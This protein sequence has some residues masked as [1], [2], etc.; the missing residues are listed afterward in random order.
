MTHFDFYRPGDL[1]EALEIVSQKGR[2]L[3]LAGGTNLLVDM[4][5]APF[6][7]HRLVDLSRLEILQQIE[8]A[9]GYIRLGAGVKLAEILRW[10]PGGAVEGLLHPM[11]A[12][13]AGPQIRNLATVGGNLCHA[14]PA[15]D[16]SPPLLALDARIELASA[17]SGI[18][19]VGLEDFF[20]GVRST[21]R[22]TDEIATVVEI[23]APDGDE[24]S[25]YYKLAKRRADA[26]S[27]V[28]VAMTLRLVAGKV[29][30]ARI[31]LGAVAPIA[32]RA[33]EAE[34]ILIGEQLKET[35][36]S[37]AAAKAATEVQP[38]DDF[39]AS[40]H[41]RQEM[42]GVL[43]KRGLVQMGSAVPGR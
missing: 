18:R 38:I 7:A 15:A 28:S 42:V 29:K 3:P 25:F 12:A 4:K 36:I 13:F 17:R 6:E 11:A 22:R 35:A 5:L 2:A 31:A 10:H 33:R 30:R 27:I 20:R 26:V 41:Y 14:S 43:V 32:V 37:A 8:P 1:A 9:N 21:A 40:A 19:R 39:R 16:C 23:P 24:S 34:K